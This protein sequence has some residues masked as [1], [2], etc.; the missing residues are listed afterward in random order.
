MSPTEITSF[1]AKV[2]PPSYAAV[3]GSTS[4]HHHHHHYNH[5]VTSPVISSPSS[6][7]P[8]VLVGRTSSESKMKVPPPVPPRGTPKVKR[9][10]ASTTT[11]TS[12]TGKGDNSF[13]MHDVFRYPLFLHDALNRVTRLVKRRDESSEFFDSDTENVR[14]KSFKKV[15]AVSNKSGH[16]SSPNVTN[17]YLDNEV[18]QI[19][20]DDGNIV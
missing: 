14:L 13:P 10:G 3:A 4:S 7:Y 11:T 1:S 15:D 20:V 6:S 19:D 5:S 17:L 8:A 12:A 2:S 18:Y 16:F 9:G